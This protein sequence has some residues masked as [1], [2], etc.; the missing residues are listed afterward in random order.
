MS[1][2]TAFQKQDLKKTD[3]INIRH[4]LRRD[5]DAVLH[6]LLP[7]AKIDEANQAKIWNKARE[8]VVDI[9]SSQLGKGGV[10]ALL[11]EFSLSSEEGIVLMCL[12]EALLRVPDKLTTN[13]LIR[14]KIM[15]GDWASHLGN[16]ESLFVNASAWGLLLTGKVI[17]FSNEAITP[18]QQEHIGLLKQ[19]INR[20]GEPV[21]RTSVRYAMQIMGT[22]FVLGKTIKSAIERSNK[23]E[24]AGYTYSYDMLGEGARTMEDADNYFHAYLEAIDTIGK[25]ATKD[26]PEA[27]PGISIKLSAL[28]PRYEF[29]QRDRVMNELV[30]RL[31][32]LAV[33]AMQH[34][35]G[36][37]VDAEEADRLDLSLD[38]IESIF[39]DSNFEGWDGFGLA[40]QAYL[41]CS[42]QVVDWVCKFASGTGRK[43]MVRLVKGAYWDSE[44]KWSQAGG[45]ADYPV[46]TR[47][48]AT[49]VCYQACA[50]KLLAHR[51][52]IYPQFATHNA[53]A[54]ASILGMDSPDSEYHRKGYEFQ[55][56]HGM[57][58]AL[59]D[60][61]LKEESIAC[62]IYAP[63]GEHA[64]LLAYLVRRLLENG[65]NSSFVN[66]VVD[67]RVPI[68]SLIE[69]P[70]G[71]VSGWKVKR[72]LNIP[73]PKNLYT[74]NEL[75]AGSRR[76]S[77]G[78]DLS[79][80][81]ILS[82]LQSQIQL[83]WETQQATLSEAEEPIINPA[84]HEEII[85]TVRFAT[86]L[87]IEQKL[88]AAHKAFAEWAETPVTQRATLLRT[89][90]DKL[91]SDRAALLMFCT[92]EA[93]KTITDG[94]SEVR[95]AVD[96]LRYYADRAEMLQTDENLIP[97]GV[98]L[99]ISPWNFPLA[100]L[101]GQVS[102]ALVTGNTVIAKPAEQT[103]LIALRVKQLMDDCDFPADVIQFV[104]S[105]GKPVGEQLVP[106][107]RIKG[108]MFTGSTD[109]G[110]WLSRAIA[111]RPDPDIPLIAETG[112]QNAMIVDSTALPEQVVDDVISSGFQSAGQ[113]CSALRVLFLQEEIA[114][115]IIELIKGAMDELSIGDP[116]LLSTDVGPVIDAETLSNLMSH[117][118]KFAH[119]PN[120]VK[121]LHECTLP[122]ASG[123]GNFFAPR[124]YEL[125]NLAILE[126][127]VF[128]PVVHVIR[129]KASMLDSVIA[130]INDTGYGLTLG[131]HSRI[132]TVTAQIA[133]TAK[134]GNLYINRNM[135]GA[136]VG[137]QPFGG[138]GLSGT[139]PKAGGP[140]YLSGMVRSAA[141]ELV[142]QAAPWLG[143]IALDE[144]SS[145]KIMNSETAQAVWA[146]VPV[147]ERVSIIRQFLAK[148]AD[149]AV[150][151]ANLNTG[152]LLSKANGLIRSVEQSLSNPVALPGPTGESNQLYLESRGVIAI[153]A[154]T[155]IS[156]SLEL[157]IATLLSG[158]GALLLCDRID[159]PLFGTCVDD[160]LALG[161]PEK[162]LCLVSRQ[163]GVET[164]KNSIIK[165]ALLAAVSTQAT[166]VRSVLASRAGL[167]TP[168]IQENDNHRMLMR[169]V[170]E[171]TI[172][173][174][175]TAAGGNASL[176]A[177]GS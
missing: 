81:T 110:L 76:N 125:N 112:G 1:T 86:A 26:T 36:F 123:A 56:L 176:M 24:A 21:I 90:A 78:V 15:T 23:S 122:D 113:R 91:E 154:D 65:A 114:S 89:L 44:I 119:Q 28:H 55:R 175:T 57:G 177:I 128:G 75:E 66:K 169:L 129:Y 120:D 108:V 37:T 88:A 95:E 67:E 116:A 51:H 161:V 103:S 150:V 4:N 157:V 118:E 42:P 74:D 47:K 73:S 97:R 164:L 13:R 58:E 22:Q 94:I 99:C 101:L 84:N 49:D 70:V 115:K 82:N 25:T 117:V 83:A 151:S 77:E 19:T 107:E 35:I 167:I 146:D 139:G 131:V 33:A 10:D 143:T 168:L 156:S 52:V 162:I 109:T 166:M 79:D 142:Q 149:N 172:S 29:L 45:Y 63:V 68:E 165:A 132:Q 31:K 54:V 137:V 152:L 64:D 72:N 61:I 98:I 155:G 20:L 170:I 46:F 80:R 104:I 171:K 138:R 85:G 3:R 7:I 2:D 100:I 53:L 27:N 12:A 163:S 105:A 159:E 102:A 14:D 174:D 87:E 59:F 43:L 124:L 60:Q 130:Q 153:V 5:E 158:N 17:S 96:F 126:G 34:N 141:Q 9:R 147:I 41:K 135:I 140:H 92:K 11:K 8:F 6:D 38:V 136:V 40:I 160:L 173:I 39:T 32:Q 18:R 133:S 127:E 71:V 30:P 106:D 145:V 144:E 111:Q 134:A 50:R 48:P 62:R 148:L 93:G 69:D 16:S 121:L